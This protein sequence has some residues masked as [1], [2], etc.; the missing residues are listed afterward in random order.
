[1]RVLVINSLQ[2]SCDKSLLGLFVFF[3][4]DVE[5]VSDNVEKNVAD[6]ISQQVT[7]VFEKLDKALQ[8]VVKDFRYSFT[9]FR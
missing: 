6:C 2:K 7:L 4:V 3:A 5:H 1:M 8:I 9:Q